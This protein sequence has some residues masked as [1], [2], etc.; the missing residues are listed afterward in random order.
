MKAKASLVKRATTGRK[1]NKKVVVFI[2][3]YFLLDNSIEKGVKLYSSIL[4]PD[5]MHLPCTSCNPSR[6]RMCPEYFYINEAGTLEIHEFSEFKFMF[7]VSIITFIA[8][9]TSLCR[10]IIST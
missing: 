9:W 10:I 6:A 1:K 3:A 4:D 5:G 2:K 7:S 8:K